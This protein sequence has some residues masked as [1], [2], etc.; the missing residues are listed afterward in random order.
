MRPPVPFPRN[1]LPQ[2][3]MIPKNEIKRMPKY[4][5]YIRTLPCVI[6]NDHTTTEAAHVRFIAP[7]GVGLKP[8]DEFTLPLCGAHHR[9]QHRRGEELWWK[10]KGLD[11]KE[12]TE[13]LWDIFN[14]F[15][16]KNQAWSNADIYLRGIHG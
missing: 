7:C 3:I 15:E 12:I 4:L 13:G 11:P 10:S 6:C 5:K 2:D 1:P 8:S 16:N 9:E 14:L